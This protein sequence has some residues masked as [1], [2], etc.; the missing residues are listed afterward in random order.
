[1]LVGGDWNHGISWL[2]IHLG[3]SSSPTDFH[4]IIFQRGWLEPPTRAG[5]HGIVRRIPNDPIAMFTV[6]IFEPPRVTFLRFGSSPFFSAQ[7]NPSFDH[8]LSPWFPIDAHFGLVLYSTCCLNV[9][10]FTYLD[11]YDWYIPFSWIGTSELRHL[12][13]PMCFWTQKYFWYI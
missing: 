9:L 2:S 12:D 6:E 7:Y 4:S 1:M 8:I 11:L 5:K 13:I 10:F 3:I